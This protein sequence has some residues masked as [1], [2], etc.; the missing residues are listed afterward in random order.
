M[1]RFNQSAR[2]MEISDVQSRPDSRRVAVDRVGVKSLRLPMLFTDADGNS[3]HTV[4][5]AAVYTNLADAARGT[6]MSR[7]VEILN[8][9]AR[10]FSYDRFRRMPAEILRRLGAEKCALSIAF[11]FFQKKRA[12]VSESES[13]M[14]S[15]AVFL[16]DADAESARFLVKVTTPVTSLCPCSKAISRHGAHN[17]RSHVTA[18][19]EPDGGGIVV[20]DLARLIEKNASAELYA[21][22]KRPD[23]K[24]VTERAYENPKFV[25]DIV[26]DLALTLAADSRVVRYRAEAENFES[27]HNHSAYAMVQSADFPPFHSA[28]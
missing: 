25:E 23:E 16:A 8:D 3:Q 2:T 13:W 14:D 21:V 10:E 20:G 1:A 18:T 11:S 17:Q 5:D 24:F 15:R 9:A 4:A 19:V 28:G 22:L 27:I 6:H 12:P 7:L 26:R